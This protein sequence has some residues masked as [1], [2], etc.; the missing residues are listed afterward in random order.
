MLCSFRNSQS[1]LSDLNCAEL[2]YKMEAIATISPLSN[3]RSATRSR[4]GGRR[5]KFSKIFV[6]ESSQTVEIRVCVNRSCSRQGSRSILDVLS[7]IAP[8]AIAVSSCGCL[9]RCGAGPNLAVIPLGS[10]VGHCS[11]AARAALVLVELC[12]PGFDAD[13]NLEALALRKKG[14]DALEKGKFDEAEA[15]LSKA[16]ELKPSGGLQ[17]V[18]RFRFCGFLLM[19][20]KVGIFLGT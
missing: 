3:W 1:S 2:S 13:R 12:G 14:E 5:R 17:F 11:T 10:V 7:S 15:M 16:I 8:L 4:G 18:Y 9:G 19:L 6:A 20:A